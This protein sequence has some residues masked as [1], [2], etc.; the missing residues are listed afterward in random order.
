MT[1]YKCNKDNYV[2]S[3][4]LVNSL[5]LCS[6]KKI[7]NANCRTCEHL[8]IDKNKPNKNESNHKL[9]YISKC[10]FKHEYEN[11]IVCNISVSGPK[12]RCIGEQNC[13]NYQTYQMLVRNSAVV[14]SEVY[15][16]TLD[17]LNARLNELEEIKKEIKLFKIE[18]NVLKQQEITLKS[19]DFLRQAIGDAKYKLFKTIGYIELKGTNEATY[20]IDIN[21]NLDRF[22]T[23]FGR[24]VC[25]YHGRIDHRNVPL[26]D[27]I[28]TICL[29]I[30][31]DSDRFDKE[32]ACGAI[33]VSV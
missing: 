16:S 27:A 13:I 29:N 11:D 2:M 30:M 33:T 25:N 1:E 23:I 7:T 22:Y 4:D 17:E 12:I 14:T 15:N 9:T 8:N 26:D 5:H 32:K 28:A 6:F 18:L 19:N 21:G 20:H 31:A 10:N 24:K 3:E